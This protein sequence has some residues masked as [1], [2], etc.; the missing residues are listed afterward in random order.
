MSACLHRSHDSPKHNQQTNKTNMTQCWRLSSNEPRTKSANEYLRT[1]TRQNTNAPTAQNAVL[2]FHRED[3][4]TH[5]N[6]TK[7]TKRPIEN[8]NKTTNKLHVVATKRLHITCLQMKPC[9]TTRQRHKEAASTRANMVFI[10]RIRTLPILFFVSKAA[11]NTTQTLMFNL[12][13]QALY[14]SDLC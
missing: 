14:F 2:H 12:Q 7:N 11:T 3:T 9:T 8:I 13:K 5:E 10:N 4:N 1:Q 6:K